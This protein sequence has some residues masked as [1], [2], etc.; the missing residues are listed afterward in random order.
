MLISGQAGIGKSSLIQRFL[1]TQ[2]GQQDT[3]SLSRTDDFSTVRETLKQLKQ[4]GA[5]KDL[6][7]VFDDVDAAPNHTQLELLRF[8]Q[9]NPKTKTLVTARSQIAFD[10]DLLNLH[11]QGLK[12]DSATELLADGGIASNYPK[13]AELAALLG[14]NPLA[15]KLAAGIAKHKSLDE[16]VRELKSNVYDL[17]D[18]T[19]ETADDAIE[20]VKPT[21][22]SAT[23]AIIANLKKHPDDIYDLPP[24]Q[25]E[26]LLATLLENMGWDVQL[27]PQS[28]DGGCDILAYLKTDLATLLC[29]VEAKRYR[30]DRPV[31][32]ELVRTLY[33][34]LNDHQASSALLATTSHFTKGAQDFQARHAYEISLKDFHDIQEWIAKYR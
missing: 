2:S 24:R 31:G 7:L 11:L 9:A 22:I 30:A 21:I 19:K 5:D 26:E 18:Q 20:I 28:G 12:A 1:A 32:V 25:F 17:K 27:T 8:L 16:I 34:T 13:A 6:L 33:G 23:D 14:N 10:F 15:L 4:L 3:I 29:L